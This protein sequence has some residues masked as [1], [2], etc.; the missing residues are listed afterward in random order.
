MRFL[1]MITA[2]T[3]VGC[4][5]PTDDSGTPATTGTTSTTTSTTSTG[6]TTTTSTT[7]TA[8]EVPNYG[9]LGSQGYTEDT[10]SIQT[11]GCTFNYTLYMPDSPASDAVVLLSHGFMRQQRHMAGWAKHMASWGLIV[12]TPSLCHVT[13]FDSDHVQNGVDL[14]ALGAHLAP[15]GDVLYVGQSAGGLASTLA[16]IADPNAVGVLGLDPVD[17]GGVGIAAA[18][19]STLE[20]H[21]LIGEG[22]S[23]NSQNNSIPMVTAAPQHQLLRIPGADHCSFESPTDVGCTLLCGGSG[24]A[25]TEDQM[26]QAVASLTTSFALWKTG[27]DPNGADFWTPGGGW[28]EQLLA[29]AWIDA[30]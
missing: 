21:A 16:A 25:L 14:R 22:G 13:A 10:G 3:L 30:D 24:G 11:G 29:S 6:T 4:G 28:Y 8:A 7:T 20:V 17:S 26:H 1:T 23:C 19:T 2:M 5:A 12:A 27:A 18:T 15:N 9:Q